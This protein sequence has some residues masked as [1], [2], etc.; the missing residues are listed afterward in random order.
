MSI[1]VM[2]E[3]NPPTV[4][5]FALDCSVAS[6]TMSASAIAAISCTIGTLSGRRRRLLHEVAAHAVRFVAEAAAPRTAA[7]RRA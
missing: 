5:S 1:A 2:N 6:E 3:T 4:I 7:R